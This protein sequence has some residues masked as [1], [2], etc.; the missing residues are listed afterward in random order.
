[1]FSGLLDF[2]QRFF[3]LFIWWTV[4][5]PWEQGIRIRLGRK[6][7]QLGPGIH[8]K[9]PYADT[10]F[11]QAVRRRYTHFGPLSVTTLDG[12]TLTVSGSLGY[13]I[14]DL[15]LL[16]DRLH[17]PEDGIHSI[18]AGAIAEYIA[19]HDL[20]ECSPPDIVA[21]VRPLLH[22]RKFGI[23]VVQLTLTQY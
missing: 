15:N 13:H 6:R 5:E 19:S 2:I 1:M 7:K 14:R 3:D 11:K 22:L 18:V 10:I 16:Y 23:G 4:I 17:H 8:F 9:I 12:Q 20:K 21:G